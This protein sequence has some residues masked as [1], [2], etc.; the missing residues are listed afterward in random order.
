ML[1]EIAAGKLLDAG[2]TGVVAVV[3]PNHGYWRFDRQM[4]EDVVINREPKRGQ[5]LSV[6]LGARGISDADMAVILPVDSAMVRTD[7][8]R[9]LVETSMKHPETII[10]PVYNGRGGHPVILSA[11]T[12]LSNRKTL[13]TEG[14]RALQYL[15][16]AEILRIKTIDGYC[17][18]DIDTLDDYFGTPCFDSISGSNVRFNGGK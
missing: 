11:A 8:L 2:C 13:L 18:H 10:K 17:V 3:G 16:E 12:L 4:F 5:G 9:T 1:I 14:L 15:P 6:L 7:T